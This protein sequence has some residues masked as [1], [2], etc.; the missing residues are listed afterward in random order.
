VENIKE[1]MVAIFDSDYNG[2]NGEESFEYWEQGTEDGIPLAIEQGFKCEAER[3]INDIY[4]NTDDD[5]SN[6]TGIM[7]KVIGCW[8]SEASQYQFAITPIDVSGKMY[9]ISVSYLS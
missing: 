8:G 7:N 2:D 5:V 1:D 6:I 4:N 9:I 3:F